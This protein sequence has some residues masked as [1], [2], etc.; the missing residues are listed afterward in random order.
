MLNPR[1][2]VCRPTT[3]TLAALFLLTVF[4]A[5]ATAEM[6]SKR[7]AVLYFENHSLFNSSTGC[8]FIPVGPIEYFWGRKKRANEWDLEVGFRR[9]MNRHLDQTEVYEP[10]TQDEILDGM[11]ALGL[12]KKNL[13][14][15]EKKRAELATKIDADALIVG[16]IR[17]FNQERIR[18]NVSR[19]MLEG[20]AQGRTLGGSFSSGIQVVGYVYIVRIDLEVDIYGR[21]GSKVATRKVSERDRHQLGGARAAAL[22]AMMTEQGSEFQLGQT[23]K[24]EAQKKRDKLRPIVAPDQLQQIQFGTPTYDRTLFGIVTNATLQKVV[25]ALRETI[26]PE[27]DAQSNPNP[28]AIQKSTP[29][30]KNKIPIGKI[31]YTDADN[32]ALTYINLGSA[33]GTKGGQKFNVFKPLVDPDSGDLLGYVSVP[34]GQ[35]EVIDV[36]TDR[37]SQVRILE[38]FG[39]LEKNQMVRLVEDTEEPSDVSEQEPPPEPKDQ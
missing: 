20:G 8:G 18:A 14:R 25:T 26:G 30:A 32:P 22:R 35:V 37:L 2:A 17:H 28:S 3:L 12:S 5:V 38:G 15:E 27:L 11:A 33:K 39:K 24:T 16:D 13:L 1:R 10:I 23:P 9:M 19:T 29:S 31:L 21:S 7:V 6:E 4:L 34:I 36:Q